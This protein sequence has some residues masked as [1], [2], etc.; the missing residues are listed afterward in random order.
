[1]DASTPPTLSPG[2]IRAR[3]YRAR[4][5]SGT[6]C[7]RVE[8]VQDAIEFLVEAGFLPAGQHHQEADIE[9]AIYELLI[10]ATRAGVTCD[11]AR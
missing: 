10:A 11:D 3:R 1:M 7:V 2:A 9:S 8:I 4:Q 5:K 6:Q